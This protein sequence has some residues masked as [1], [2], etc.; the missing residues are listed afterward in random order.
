MFDL[1]NLP[2]EP[3]VP[4]ECTEDIRPQFDLS[5][6]SDKIE[7]VVHLKDGRTLTFRKYLPDE[8]PP[9]PVYPV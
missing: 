2:G 7:E 4:S 6:L 3:I 9:A 5:R 1:S 8:P